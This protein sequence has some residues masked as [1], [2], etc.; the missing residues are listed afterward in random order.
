M[1]RTLTPER[2]KLK[3]EALSLRYDYG[4]SIPKIMAQL[5]LKRRTIYRYL[6]HNSHGGLCHNSTKITHLEG[7]CLEFLGVANDERQER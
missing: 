1:A 5:N 6:C 2:Q 7:D 3:Q 4:L